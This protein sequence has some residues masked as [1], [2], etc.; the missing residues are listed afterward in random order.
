VGTVD[1]NTEVR[2]IRGV[3][4]ARAEQ[5]ARLGV[6]TVGDL[7][8]LLPKR[9][10]HRPTSCGIGELVEA[11]PATVIG[12]VTRVRTSPGYARASVMVTLEDG[13]GKCRGRWFNASYMR[14]RIAVGQTLRISGKVG[15][16]DYG[17][18]FVN[19][20]W[21]VIDETEDL[22]QVDAEQFLPVYPGTQQL[23][24][25]LVARAVRQVADAIADAP[26]LLPDEILKRRRLPPRRVALA[27]I[28]NPTSLED[29]EIARRRLAYDELLLMQLAVQL[30][31]ASRQ[32]QRDAR[33]LSVTDRI[34]E[35]IRTRL[36]FELTDAQNR[37]IQEI[38]RD[39]ASDQPMARLLQGDVGSGKTAVAIYASLVAVANRGQVAWL[40]PT[41]VLSRQTFERVRQYLYDSR[42]RLEHLIGATPVARR[43]TILS[44]LTEGQ[45]DIVVGTHA[46]IEK[47]V[48]FGKLALVV[49]DEQHRFGVRQRSSI[50]SKGT[51]PHY[52]VMT[53]TP[54]P[55]TLA[56]TLFGD[57]DVSVIDALPPGRSPVMTRMI[58]PPDRAEAW[59]FV[60]RHVANG[61]QAYVVY[62]L[63]DP[64]DTLELKS[65]TEALEQLRNGELADVRIDLLHGQMS[66]EQKEQAIAAFRD[67]RTQV[68]VA[69]TVIEVG[70]DVPAATIMVIEH[71]DRFGL[72]QLHQLRGRVGRGR[73]QGYCLLM[74]D[75]LSAKARERLAL[76]CSTTDGFALA[77]ADLT[78]RGPGELLGT[79]QHGLPVLKVADMTRDIDLLT[80]AR[81][82]AARIL[83][84]DPQLV[85]S[86]HRRVRSESARQYA[87]VVTGNQRA[88]R[89]AEPPRDGTTA[90]S[91]D[92]RAHGPQTTRPRTG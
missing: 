46:L 43:R 86:T 36:P 82:D 2:F 38:Q 13:T 5:F 55:R 81:D 29:A 24:S 21:Q 16:D 49:V 34:D 42:V 15:V 74:A 66:A 41:E 71:A 1:L 76:L 59:S 28:H 62:P 39:L 8:E 80:I 9:Y 87:D 12:L 91:S 3:G 33:P 92:R 20:S 84:D 65:A 78:L 68:L 44:K 7:I 23:T 48:L 67:G 51:A 58:G 19:P 79:R 61:E 35:R 52:L 26:E 53:A 11:Q 89:S 17:A 40:A 47:D 69:T 31:R 77:E 4:P 83:A 88:D 60:R 63:V 37:V 64:S 14:D 30:R 72:S 54:I 56:M 18:V 25:R 57:L 73:G 10:E 70:V 22:S 85:R 75:E 90:R 6:R 50:R 45:I 32:S 27:R